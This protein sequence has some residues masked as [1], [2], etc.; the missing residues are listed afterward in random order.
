MNLPENVSEKLESLYFEF[1]KKKL[2]STQENLTKKY[3]TETGNSVNKIETKEAGLLYAISRMPATFAVTKSVL[4][5]MVIENNFNDIETIFDIGSGTGAGYLALSETFE[6][7]DI[8]LFEREDNMI[9]AFSKIFDYPVSKFDIVHSKINEKSDLVLCSYVLSEMTES[10]R[11]IA[12]DNLLKMTDKYLLLIDTGTPET[13]REYME[14]KKYVLNSGYSVIAPCKTNC[15]DLGEDYCQFYARVERSKLMKM[16]KDAELSY[17]DEKY[18]Y[19]LISKEK[20]QENNKCRVIRRPSYETNRVKLVVC[21]DG[22][23]DIVIT[24][25]DKEKYKK[26]RKIKINEEF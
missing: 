10:D 12:I 8:K 9:F 13:F 7:A 19:L 17:E 4:D 24:K 3:K 25:S 21:D 14:I 20:T 22:K 26:S 6:N 15:C 5:E 18:F 2:K 11:K 1:D 16:A 23:K